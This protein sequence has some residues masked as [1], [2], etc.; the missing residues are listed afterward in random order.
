MAQEEMTSDTGS[1]EPT[2][3]HGFE[4][5]AYGIAPDPAIVKQ[6]TEERGQA[7]GF[8]GVT[9]DPMRGDGACWIA[10]EDPNHPGSIRRRTCHV[11]EDAAGR[12]VDYA[13]LERGERSCCFPGT[14]YAQ[15]GGAWVYNVDDPV[16]AAKV[17][18]ERA[19]VAAHAHAATAADVSK[20]RA[21]A[22]EG[23]YT[24]IYLAHAD[25]PESEWSWAA[26]LGYDGQRIPLGTYPTKKAAARAV[27]IGRLERRLA[28]VNFRPEDYKCDAGGIWVQCAPPD[29]VEDAAEIER[30]AAWTAAGRWGS[31]P[32]TTATG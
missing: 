28:T 2:V 19:A 12:A 13:R 20:K 32:S 4:V 23:K 8:P 21:A 3:G 29:V 18:A 14:D 5:Y 7:S 1:R 15:E 27:D 30:C 31:G 25:R 26:R 16:V 9:R 24:G 11:T 17:A 6:L 10:Q 22:D